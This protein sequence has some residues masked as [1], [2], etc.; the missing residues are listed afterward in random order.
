MTKRFTAVSLLILVMLLTSCSSTKRSP[1]QAAKKPCATFDTLTERLE[2]LDRV[3]VMKNAKIASQQFADITS[4]DPQ[5]GEFANFLKEVSETG[6][7]GDPL[8]TYSDLL[9]YCIPINKSK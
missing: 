4:L 8:G 3:G 5:F 7:L 6:S 2:V 1:E 9:L